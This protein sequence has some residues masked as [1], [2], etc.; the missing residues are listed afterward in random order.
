MQKPQ[1][2]KTSERMTRTRT[3]LYVRVKQ[4][5]RW[6]RWHFYFNMKHFAWSIKERLVIFELSCLNS[7]FVYMNTHKH[8]RTCMRIDKHHT[9]TMTITSWSWWERNVILNVIAKYFYYCCC[10]LG[11]GSIGKYMKFKRIFFKSYPKLLLEWGEG[12]KESGKKKPQRMKRKTCKKKK[13]EKL[14]QRVENKTQNTSTDLSWSLRWEFESAPL[15][16]TLSCSLAVPDVCVLSVCFWLWRTQER[17]IIAPFPEM[18]LRYGRVN[19]S[20]SS[21][22]WSQSS[23]S[24]SRGWDGGLMDTS[25]WQGRCSTFCISFL[26]PATHSLSASVGQQVTPL[27]A[28]MTTWT[29]LKKPG[30][31]VISSHT[32]THSCLCGSILPGAV[33]F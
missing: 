3:S 29:R 32:Q 12:W 14:N 25:A 27:W 8:T 23:S 30:C 18:N 4:L 13:K 33:R 17:L 16:P 31:C 20:I 21:K 7:V 10:Y 9:P 19:G 22:R 11:N 5:N 1:R 2:F 24:Q 6:G 28:F 15:A 26:Q